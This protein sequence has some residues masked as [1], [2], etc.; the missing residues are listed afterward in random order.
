MTFRPFFVIALTA[1]TA[2]GS[3]ALAETDHGHGAGGASSGMSTH[4]G[5]MPGMMMKMADKDGDGTVSADEMR[6][7]MQ[8]RLSENDANGDGSLSPAEFEAMHIKMMQQHL[9]ERFAQLDTDGNGALSSDEMAA[10][11]EMMSKMHSGAGDMDHGS[12]KKQD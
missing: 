12:Q 10:H 1:S 8:A 3:A 4:S 11:A 5:M 7:M 2:L 9:S 6:D